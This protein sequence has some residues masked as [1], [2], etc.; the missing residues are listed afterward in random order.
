MKRLFLLFLIMLL[1]AAGQVSADTLK[2][3]PG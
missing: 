1:W 2:E 3:F